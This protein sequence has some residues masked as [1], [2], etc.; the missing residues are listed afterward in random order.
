MNLDLLKK[1]LNN[2]IMIRKLTYLTFLVSVFMQAQTSDLRKI[3]FEV[4]KQDF[5]S[6]LPFDESFKLVFESDYKIS[7]ITL[8]YRI[9]DH[10][11]SNNGQEGGL[12]KTL[13]EKKH[14]FQYTSA[15]EDG[16]IEKNLHQ[17][18]SK[19]FSLSNIGPL[20]ANTPYEFVFTI[21]TKAT[22]SDT[23]SDEL[24]KSLNSAIDRLYLKES[25]PA[26]DVIKRE[27]NTS[28]NNIVLQ[29]LYDSQGIPIPIKNV[30]TQDLGN[31]LGGLITLDTDLND[32][33]GDYDTDY[34]GILSVFSTD[35]IN[36]FKSGLESINENTLKHGSVLKQPINGLI[37]GY[38][39]VTLKELIDFILIDLQRDKIYLKS[40]LGGKA[41]YKGIIPEILSAKDRYDTKSLQLLANTFEILRILGDKNDNLF[42]EDCQSEMSSIVMA[43]SGDNSPSLNLVQQAKLINE[44]VALIEKETN[45]LPNIIENKHFSQDLNVSYNTTIDVESK[46]IPYINLDLGVLYARELDDFF[47]MQIVNFHAKPVNRKSH[48]SDLKCWDKFF[49]QASLQI[50]IAQKLG[51]D[52]D[53]FSGL[54]GDVGTP[55]FGFGFRFNRFLRI[56]SGLIIYELKSSNPVI[57]RKVDKGSLS[58]NISINSSLSE[59]LGLIGGI[60]NPK[61]S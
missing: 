58:F 61:K 26:P 30:I 51:G 48:F 45:S 3:T 42:F 49:K 31:V 56:G 20:H 5:K 29:P 55:Y 41:K 19:N 39:K 59:A 27:F 36:K 33:I 21:F 38:E 43:L 25:L 7:G 24:K 9:K 11:K 57:S 35:F 12:G 32:L 44:T 13:D 37:D 40:I 50:G 16:F 14:Y 47:A 1:L 53:N 10:L 4:N 28:I 23:K 2:R 17:I 18:N 34:N 22:I 52:N 46:A 6:S 60:I 8:K 15:N 54:L